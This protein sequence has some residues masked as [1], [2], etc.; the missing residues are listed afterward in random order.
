[1]ARATKT[2]QTSHGAAA[3]V[4]KPLESARKQS[5]GDDAAALQPVSA[6]ALHSNS[7]AKSKSRAVI[8]GQQASK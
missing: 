6:R 3:G 5:K 1:M 8:F 7:E 4:A 2:S